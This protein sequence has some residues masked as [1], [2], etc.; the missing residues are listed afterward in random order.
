MMTAM[1]SFSEAAG[2]TLSFFAA[3]MKTTFQPEC[4]SVLTSLAINTFVLCIVHI[5]Q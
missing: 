4:D 2:E 3:T 1:Y 5:H